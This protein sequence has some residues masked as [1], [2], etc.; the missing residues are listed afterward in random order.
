MA[1]K[2]DHS[3]LYGVL[4]GFGLFVLLPLLIALYFIWPSYMYSKAHPF[5]PEGTQLTRTDDRGFRE[6][7][8]ATDTANI[9][10][11]VSEEFAQK[12]REDRF[13]ETPLSDFAQQTL[14]DIRELEYVDQITNG[15]WLFWND[16]PEETSNGECTD[17]RIEIYDLD[18]CN[19]CS[20]EYDS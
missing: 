15:P 13:K 2:R 18:A 14:L 17:F 20:I 19:Y 4:G 1:Q 12:L 10:P 3:M 8:A 6:G 11:E 7:G 16:S 5:Y 9:P